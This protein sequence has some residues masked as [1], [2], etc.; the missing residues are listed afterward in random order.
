MTIV[1]T[2][3]DLAAVNLAVPLPL[4][5]QTIGYG[6]CA[7]W[8][9]THPDPPAVHGNKPLWNKSERDNVAHFLKEAQDEIENVTRYHLIPTWITA[10][11]HDYG[12]PLLAEWTRLIEAGIE[13]STTISSGEAVDHTDDPAVI[14]PVATTVTDTDEIVI[15]YPGTEVIIHPSDIT[16]AAGNVTIE[17]PRCR[18]QTEDAQSETGGTD[19]ND[20]ALGGPFLQTVDVVRVYN[21]DSTQATL[22]W[23]HGTTSTGCP[24]C[25]GDTRD[26]CIVLLNAK[27]GKLD[28]TPATYSGGTW[29]GQSWECYCHYPDRVELNY[30]G[31]LTTLTRQARDAVIR[32]AHSKM[33]ANPCNV[34]PPLWMWSRD[35]E[36]P[37]AMTKERLNCP[38]GLAEGAWIAY[39]FARSMKLMRGRSL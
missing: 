33:P 22:V 3:S 38:F 13:A 20:T 8:G 4:Y 21:D 24:Q 36:V 30:R 27:I 1:P 6:E 28:V 23:S 9:V 29:T 37:R 26:A 7:F 11:G 39:K 5:A 34:S 32:L 2:V 19:Y 10:E 35:R 31:G 14:G 18:L 17:I 16:I 12:Y 25:S 15:Y